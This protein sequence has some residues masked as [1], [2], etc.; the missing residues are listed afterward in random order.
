MY[1][2]MELIQPRPSISAT[3]PEARVFIVTRNLYLRP[4]WPEE[5]R[6]LARLV[7][8]SMPDAGFPLSH[9]WNSSVSFSQPGKVETIV[10]CQRAEPLKPIGG[11]FVFRT[12]T[13]GFDFS[14]WLSRQ[15]A[16]RGFECEI[17]LAVAEFLATLRRIQRKQT[18]DTP[19]S[20]G[21]STR[22]VGAKEACA[23]T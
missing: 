7:T 1:K 5:R 22:N 3:P 23:H 6:H 12:G 20:A 4:V 16:M 9:T 8:I 19:R 10:A 14:V 21:I 13:G 17:S 18:G 11:A 15:R 2:C